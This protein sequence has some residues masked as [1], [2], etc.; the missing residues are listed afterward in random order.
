MIKKLL[1]QIRV[2]LFHNSVNLLRRYRFP[3]K[4]KTLGFLCDYINHE[5]FYLT[6]E[7]I[8]LKNRIITLYVP[9]SHG[10]SPKTVFAFVIMRKKL[11]MQ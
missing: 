2:K 7:A 11:T 10:I 3:E 5:D 6:E 4:Y 1:K 8:A 9:H